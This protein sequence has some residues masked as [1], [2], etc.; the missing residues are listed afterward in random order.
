MLNPDKYYLSLAYAVAEAS[1]EEDHKVGCIIVDEYTGAVISSG[2]NRRSG[3]PDQEIIYHAEE[4]ALMAMAQSG[5]CA[6]N[7]ILYVTMA[8]CITCAKLIVQAGIYKV[9]YDKPYKYPEGVDFLKN[10]VFINGKDSH[11]SLINEE[12]LYKMGYYL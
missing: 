7:K 9:I 10:K 8:P 6:R 1:V 12:E 11:H 4:S 3:K 2:Y 5:I